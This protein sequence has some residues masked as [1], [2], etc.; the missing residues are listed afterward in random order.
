[1]F[2]VVLEGGLSSAQEDEPQ[3][4]GID[5]RKEYGGKGK[6]TGT[7]RKCSANF[8]QSP[9]KFG[10]IVCGG[11][12]TVAGGSGGAVAAA[13]G[14]GKGKVTG[15]NSKQPSDRSV[16][17]GGGGVGEEPSVSGDGGMEVAVDNN[18]NQPSN[19]LGRLCE[20]VGKARGSSVC[21]YCLGVCCS[22]MQDLINV[23]VEFGE[24][25]P[26]QKVCLVLINDVLN[27]CLEL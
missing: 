26:N 5:I 13:S 14:G 12:G 6:A 8:N 25:K 17:M 19:R 10:E 22:S 24:A 7:R 3:F 27:L 18:S 1:M 21:T 15:G 23:L 11:A 16:K 9:R 4:G 20:N 2:C